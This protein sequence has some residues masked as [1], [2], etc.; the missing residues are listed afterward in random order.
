MAK[1][2]A[3]T[4]PKKQGK[5][6]E[7]NTVLE[8]RRREN[9]Q[10]RGNLF[11]GLI[12]GASMIVEIIRLLHDVQNPDSIHLSYYARKTCLLMHPYELRLLLR[13]HKL[14]IV[15]VVR[16]DGLISHDIHSFILMPLCRGILIIWSATLGD[17]LVP[18]QLFGFCANFLV[19]HLKRSRR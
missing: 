15:P 9:S 1:L 17:I 14:G 3:K 8:R 6:N 18:P 10:N 16:L 2:C 13:H 7:R 5:R 12:V 11:R 4:T 19:R